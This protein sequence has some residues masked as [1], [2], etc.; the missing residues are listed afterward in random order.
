MF[1]KSNLIKRFENL[2]KGELALFV[3]K[4]LVTLTRSEKINNRCSLQGFNVNFNRGD[5]KKAY[6]FKIE[7]AIRY[8]KLNKN[9][10]LALRASN[11]LDIFNQE[12]V[13]ETIPLSRV[14][15]DYLKKREK[16]K[17]LIVKS[18][19]TKGAKFLYCGP[20]TMLNEINFKKY[21][22]IVFNKPLID[23]QLP[24]P[25]EKLIIILNNTWSMNEF[26]KI[27]YKWGYE[28][29]S[30][31]FF[32]PNFLGLKNENNKIFKLIP[33]FLNASPMGLQRTL[34]VIL[35]YYNV[36]SLEVV[37]ADFDLTLN[38]YLSWYPRAN[39]ELKGNG[40]IGTNRIHDFLFNFLYTKKIKLEVNKIFYGSLDRYLEMPI[41][42]II[43]LFEEKTMNYRK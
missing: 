23:Q 28:N 39:I 33:N 37:G 31:Q 5:L 3:Y 38:S 32:S 26:K 6:R 1:F 42:D 16:S 35:N 41:R 8:E 30:V 36:C 21:D 15:S 12:D 43:Y 4:I 40:F 27:T 2:Y 19:N 9:N 17:N 13:L 14:T 22:F 20:A 18:I 34:F 29:S 7:Q 24:I 11:Y 25:N 10:V